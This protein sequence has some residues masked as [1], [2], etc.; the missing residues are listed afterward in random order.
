MNLEVNRKGKLEKLQIC[1]NYTTLLNNQWLKEE[2]KRKT[3]IYLETNGKTT[4]QKW[5]ATEAVLKRK[6]IPLNTYIMK[7]KIISNK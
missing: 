5:N 6:F 3:R 4:Y 2:L 1:G 7:R